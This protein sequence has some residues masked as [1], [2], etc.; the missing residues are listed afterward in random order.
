[1]SKKVSPVL[2]QLDALLPVPYSVEFAFRILS[3]SPH[4]RE[5]LAKILARDEALDRQVLGTRH[6]TIEPGDPP[7]PSPLARGPVASR[8]G[9]ARPRGRG[10][11]HDPRTASLSF[12]LPLGPGPCSASCWN[13]PPRASDRSSASNS[14][15]CR[16][17][18]SSPRAGSKPGRTLCSGPPRRRVPRTSIPRKRS[19]C[20]PYGSTRRV[21]GRPGY[22]GVQDR[23]GDPLFAGSRRGGAS[24]TVHPLPVLPLLGDLLI[25]WPGPVAPD[26]AVV[27]LWVELRGELRRDEQG[28]LFVGVRPVRIVEVPAFGFSA[29]P[30][31][32]FK[33]FLYKGLLGLAA[34]RSASCSSRSPCTPRVPQE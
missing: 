21:D 24:H 33:V 11:C 31:G 18:C 14:R 28:Y 1:M 27:P 17:S 8:V 2:L 6:L 25:L 16:S 9:C 13:T 30:V 32:C 22:A 26:A 10:A 29:L 3:V 34:R 12:Q 4:R 19:S 23:R 7:A 20:C 15:P 5:P